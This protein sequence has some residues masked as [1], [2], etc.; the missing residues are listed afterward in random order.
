MDQFLNN[1]QCEEAYPESEL[2]EQTEVM[3]ALSHPVLLLPPHKEMEN[4][5]KV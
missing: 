5:S 1:I 2:Q 4:E 3:Q